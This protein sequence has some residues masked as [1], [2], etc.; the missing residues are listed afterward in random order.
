MRIQKET[1]RPTKSLLAAAALV[2][3]GVLASA[4]TAQ[5]CAVCFGDP[6]SQ[7][8][9]AM[10]PGILFLLGCIGT[11][12]SGFGVMF[13]YWARRMKRAHALN[14]GAIG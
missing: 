9:K 8:T 10:A 13:C 5:A 4:G 1:E 2:L 3:L 6:N 12:L 7:L 14:D 11:V